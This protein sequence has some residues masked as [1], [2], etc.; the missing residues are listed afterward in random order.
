[1][2]GKLTTFGEDHTLIVLLL[3]ELAMLGLFGRRSTGRRSA[4]E[5]E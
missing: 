1:M 5:E 2:L 4:A 3:A